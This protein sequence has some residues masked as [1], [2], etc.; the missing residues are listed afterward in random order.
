MDKVCSSELEKGLG[1]REV[2]TFE[3]LF[4]SI[5]K[6]YLRV[7]QFDKEI[8]TVVRSVLDKMG[9]PKNSFLPLLNDSLNAATPEQL[10]ENLGNFIVEFLLRASNYKIPFAAFEK[11]T[12]NFLYYKEKGYITGEPLPKYQDI[13]ILFRLPPKYFNIYLNI[14]NYGK[15]ILKSKS[16]IESKIN[17]LIKKDENPLIVMKYIMKFSTIFSQGEDPKGFLSSLDVALLVKNIITKKNFNDMML[18]F[19]LLKYFP[20]YTNSIAKLFI[21]ENKEKNF[22]SIINKVG[23]LGY[24]DTENLKE[25]ET[26]E[27]IG[28]LNFLFS[29]FIKGETYLLV[30][31]DILWD[32]EFLLDQLCQR[33]NRKGFRH[34]AAQ[35]RKRNYTEED[36]EILES[37]YQEEEYFKLPAN[38]K[39]RL[40]SDDS[41]E[42]IA[43]IESFKTQDYFG[44]DSETKPEFTSLKKGEKKTSDIIQIS[45]KEAV[46]II[47]CKKFQQSNKLISKVAEVF[48]NKT[49]IGFSF[50]NDTELMFVEFKDVF[51]RNFI[52]LASLYKSK[53]KKP[54]PSLKAVCKEVLDVNLNK[55]WQI[56]N[57]SR[58]PLRKGQMEYCCIDAY[59]IPLIY[60][61]IKSCY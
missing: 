13:E 60:E 15:I 41:E 56:S 21:Q 5:V 24:L 10:K 23:L 29:K 46:L 34:E 3:E 25:I 33:L 40:V 55:K 16:E 31:Y 12:K 1:S 39:V 9:R 26:K 6:G 43:F 28:Y 45:S 44:I 35:I 47:D 57:W 53:F 20:N 14:F 52:E 17:D 22:I 59:V 61:K 11:I 36:D 42:N 19:N 48:G 32:N 50:A 4:D 27:E 30:I 2:R 49:F 58:R 18:Y 7:N 37:R 51:L 38:I 54:C 8:Q